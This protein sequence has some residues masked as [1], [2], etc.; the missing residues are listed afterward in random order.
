MEPSESN[1]AIGSYNIAHDL[2]VEAHA[3]VSDAHRI[4]QE[5]GRYDDAAAE[6]GD[7]LIALQSWLVHHGPLPAPPGARPSRYGPRQ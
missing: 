2:I 5:T 1:Q 6:L 4:L 3:K 7:P